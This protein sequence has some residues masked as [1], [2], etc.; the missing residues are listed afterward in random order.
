MPAGAPAFGRR[1]RG[2]ESPTT[3]S[4]CSGAA[5]RGGFVTARSRK[6][7]PGRQ[8]R[9]VVIAISLRAL[10]TLREN[11]SALVAPSL[12]SGFPPVCRPPLRAARARRIF[13]R[14]EY[15]LTRPE[16]SSI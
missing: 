11:Y 8:E 12:W 6:A 2:E 1:H 15:G 4:T 7:R 13:H 14:N 9:L 16:R 3:S 5:C 10:R